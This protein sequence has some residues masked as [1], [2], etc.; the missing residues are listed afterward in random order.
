M[1]FNKES[2]MNPVNLASLSRA[3]VLK[4]IL[5]CV[6]VLSPLLAS[7]EGL[8]SS[9]LLGIGDE[10]FNFKSYRPS[11]FGFRVNHSDKDNE[12]EI[13][14]QLSLKYQLT[15]SNVFEDKYY[16]NHVLS[17][18]YF[19]Y[20][21][22]SFWSVQKESAPFREN[23]F[24]PEFFKEAHFSEWGSEDTFK[25]LRFGLFQHESTGEAG[26]G[27]QGWNLTYIEPVWKFGGVSLAPKI[28]VPF[29]FRSKEKVAPDNPDIFDYYGYGEIKLSY[30]QSDH[31]RHSMMYRQGSSS[32][33]YGFQWQTDFAFKLDIL[34]PKVFIQYW[35]GY[36]ES[37]KDYNNNTTGLVL[38]LSAVY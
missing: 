1:I 7:A 10:D 36:G 19:G 34:N 35:S 4:C 17:N 8:S 37:L 32:D 5:V 25:F 30:D 15:R 21:Q 22:K 20:T 6:S 24:S 18:W 11:Y 13:K 28:W 2:N 27:S 31:W 26:T 29:L 16:A 38:G 33:L 12:G 23:N 14:F 9:S 3:I